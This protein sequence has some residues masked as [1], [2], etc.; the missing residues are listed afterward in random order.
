MS[1][2]IQKITYSATAAAGLGV[3]GDGSAALGAGVVLVDERLHFELG[4]Y[5][6]F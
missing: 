4:S 2:G 5:D 1:S 6:G 3:T